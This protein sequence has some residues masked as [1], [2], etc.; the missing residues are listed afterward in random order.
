MM[1]RKWEN[2]NDSHVYYRVLP[3]GIGFSFIFKGFEYMHQKGINFLTAV[4]L[5]DI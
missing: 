3:L 5:H 4:P 1:Q 2:S